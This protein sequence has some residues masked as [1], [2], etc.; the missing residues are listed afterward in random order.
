MAIDRSPG[1]A[2]V[3]LP[4]INLFDPATQATVTPIPTDLVVKPDS[5]QGS[6]AG[7]APPLPNGQIFIGPPWGTSLTGA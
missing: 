4:L 1:W 5:W 7:G 3:T 6:W 2:G